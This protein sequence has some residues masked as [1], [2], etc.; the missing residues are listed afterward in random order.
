MS[1]PK[2][3]AKRLCSLRKTVWRKAR[4][5]KIVFLSSPNENIRITLENIER[6]IQHGQP[7]ETR[8]IG[9]TRQ[10]KT[11][12]KYNTIC[13]KNHYAQTNTNNVN[14]TCTLLQTTGGKDEPN[15]ILMRQS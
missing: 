14:K 8:N 3:A 7:R 2:T 6:A 10:G 11:K 15:I 4:E 13:V 5:G 12:Q 1:L 9:Y